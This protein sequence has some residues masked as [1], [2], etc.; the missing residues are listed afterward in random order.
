MSREPTSI[1]LLKS[2]CIGKGAVVPAEFPDA[3]AVLISGRNSGAK[4]SRL[5]T[6]LR[7]APCRA[8]P[9]RA[10]RGTPIVVFN[11][12]R[13]RTLERFTGPDP[14]VD[15]TWARQKGPGGGTRSED[16]NRGTQWLGSLIPKRFQA[17]WR[18]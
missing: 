10:R 16:E 13:E 9:R 18:S 7:A 4:D 6:E 3:G 12:L 2:T 14:P 5:K 15:V 17:G 8:A 11:P 1:G